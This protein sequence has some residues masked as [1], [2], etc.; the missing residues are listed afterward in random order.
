M[1]PMVK[2]WRAMDAEFG[3]LSPFYSDPGTRQEMCPA[4]LKLDVPAQLSQSRSLLKGPG[5]MAERG[6]DCLLSSC[7][8][9]GFGSPHP[10]GS[11]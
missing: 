10:H 7:I 6:Q 11:S 3:L 5:G 2:M 4:Q 8:G 9:P 1:A